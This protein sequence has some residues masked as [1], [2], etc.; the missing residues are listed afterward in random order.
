MKACVAASESRV[1]IVDQVNLKINGVLEEEIKH[2]S[3]M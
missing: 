3:E 2:G 1:Y